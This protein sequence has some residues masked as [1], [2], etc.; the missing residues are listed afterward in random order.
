[1]GIGCCR[2]ECGR[3]TA[4]WLAGWQDPRPSAIVVKHVKRQQFWMGL[5]NGDRDVRDL[6]T[7]KTFRRASA[8]ERAR[9]EGTRKRT[10]IRAVGLGGR[11]E[12]RRARR[13]ALPVAMQWDQP[14]NGNGNR[15]PN[16]C[17]PDQTSRRSCARGV[18]RVCDVEVSSRLKSTCSAMQRNAWPVVVE[19]RVAEQ[20]APS[21]PALPPP[22]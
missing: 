9:W 2:V 4:G 13:R 15:R 3:A 16:A 14:G 10:R 21:P 22:P 8:R 7:L 6:Q 1:M 11:D 18:G 19:G 17:R 20:P 12:T 5:R